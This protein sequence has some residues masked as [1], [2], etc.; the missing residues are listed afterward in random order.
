LVDESHIEQRAR[1][2][3]NIGVCTSLLEQ[4]RSAGQWFAKSIDSAPA[5]SSIP[6][7]NSARVDIELLDFDGAINSLRLCQMRFPEAE[8]QLVPLLAMC[9][10]E[11]G[12]EIEAARELRRGIQ[13][14]ADSSLAYSILGAIIV[15]GEIRDR[16]GA[17]AVLEEG[18]AKYP[19]DPQIGNN[20]AYAYLQAGLPG[21]ARTVLEEVKGDGDTEVTLS[22][23]WGLLRLWEGDLQ[24]GEELYRRAKSL[25]RRK[26][27]GR[28]AEQVQQKMH[29]ELARYYLRKREITKA[30]PEIRKGLNLK[31][32]RSFRLDLDSLRSELERIS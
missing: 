19:H 20:L 2:L 18:Y 1:I 31:G 13:K 15:E 21:R 16:D 26:Q 10:I 24:E 11:R 14:G 9:L 22:A 23:T 17:I 6:Y 27:Q 30:L 12:D 7:L 32:R 8:R 29:L 5:A 25:A 4:R 28:L 3:N